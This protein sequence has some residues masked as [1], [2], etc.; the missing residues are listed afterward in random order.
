MFQ[1]HHGGLYFNINGDTFKPDIFY[2]LKYFKDLREQ[3]TEILFNTN[4]HPDADKG[5]MKVWIDGKMKI[6]YK[7]TANHPEGKDLN[8][9]YGIYT[10]FLDKYR[11]TFSET[12]HKQRVLYFDGVR[13]DTTCKKL[14]KDNKRCNELLSQTVSEYRIYNPNNFKTVKKF[15]EDDL[16]SLVE[17]AI[18]D[19]GNNSN[20]GKYV[21]D[22]FSTQE[23]NFLMTAKD[24]D[25]KCIRKELGPGLDLL[26]KDT[27]NHKRYTRPIIITWIKKIIKNCSS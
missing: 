3:W 18:L 2:H 25:E 21:H 19:N 7:G 6:D 11:N 20:S 15:K 12:K 8:L 1:L 14:L 5:F 9:R 22:D 13:G 10:S 23:I 16:K 4:W 26:R 24:E 17:P 27:I